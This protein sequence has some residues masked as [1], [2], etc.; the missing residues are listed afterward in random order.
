MHDSVQ[1][2]CCCELT[3][4]MT[5]IVILSDGIMIHQCGRVLPHTCEH[6]AGMLLTVCLFCPILMSIMT[7][8]LIVDLVC[9][10]LMSIMKACFDCG[11]VLPHICERHERMLL[12]GNS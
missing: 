3:D 12:M 6:H 11:L 4:S 1:F 9:P 7:A 10:K 2:F 5:V 8:C